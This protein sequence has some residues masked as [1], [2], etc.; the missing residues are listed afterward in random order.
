MSESHVRDIGVAE[1]KDLP[2]IPV[3][4]MGDMLFLP[5]PIQAHEVGKSLNFATGW[6]GKEEELQ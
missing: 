3:Y 2:N 1:V 6:E 5:L 4:G